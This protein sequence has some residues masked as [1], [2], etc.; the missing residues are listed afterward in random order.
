MSKKAVIGIGNV[1][2]RDD[3]VGIIILEKI[4]R[5]CRDHGID[6]LDFGTASFD[7]IH[8]FELYQK[9]LIIDAAKCGLLPGE[10]MIFNLSKAKYI[11]ENNMTSTHEIGLK[12]LFELVNRFGLKTEIII[13]GVET[14]DQSFGEGLSD[15]VRKGLPV[16][17]D[18][19]SEYIKN[20]F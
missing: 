16:I 11:I 13:A 10:L 2:R 8:K 4:S 14:E 3:G 12:S 6:I 7:L 5:L 20:E 17:I 15:P 19:I 1:L 18:K 9:V